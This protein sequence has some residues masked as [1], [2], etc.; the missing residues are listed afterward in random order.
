[1]CTAVFEN[2]LVIRKYGNIGFFLVVI[3]LQLSGNFLN[4]GAYVSPLPVIEQFLNSKIRPDKFLALLSAQTIGGYSAF[5]LANALWYY[6]LNYSADHFQLFEHLPCAIVYKVPY[7]YA[8]LNELV[9]SFLLRYIINRLPN[10]SKFYITPALVA[11]LLTFSLSFIGIPGLNPVVT[12]SRLQGCP[13]LD[14]QWFMIT[15]WVC[16]AIGWLLAAQLDKN[17]KARG[18][19]KKEKQKKS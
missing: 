9:G 7:S 18:G 6:S 3:A 17:S 2:A 16:P 19:S 4:R 8:F 13:G 12:S 11:S 14:L 1:M 5:R 15:Y 10:S